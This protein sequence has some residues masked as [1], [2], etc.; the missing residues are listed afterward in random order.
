MKEKLKAIK[1][2]ATRR[3][4]IEKRQHTYFVELEK[5]MRIADDKYYAGKVE[6]KEEP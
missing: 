1:K 2:A 3:D 6:P 5:A 4:E